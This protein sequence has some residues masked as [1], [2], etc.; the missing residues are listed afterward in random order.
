MIAVRIQRPHA[1][2]G[3]HDGGG[4]QRVHGQD[5]EE[6]TKPFQS[7]EPELRE[8]GFPR[9]QTAAERW[10]LLRHDPECHRQ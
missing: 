4:L 9:R 7:F 3:G 5:P 8:Q 2:Q 6:V 10:R 1:S